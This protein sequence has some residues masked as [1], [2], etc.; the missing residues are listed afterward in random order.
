MNTFAVKLTPPYEK[1]GLSGEGLSPSLT[2]IIHD[3]DPDRKFPALIAVPGGSYEH[4]SKREGEP[5]A[6]RWYSHGYN[7]F[8]LEYSCVDKP[9]PT[10]LLEL[11]AAVEYIRSNADS[12]SCDGRI[13]LCGFSAGGHL[14]ASLGVH[15]ERY[16]EFFAENIRPDKMILCYPVITSGEYTHPL[17]AKNIAPTEKLKALAAL[18]NH[19]SEKTPPTFIWHCADDNIVS[20]ENSLMFASALSK[21]KVPYE[22]HIFPKGGHGIAM[23]DITTIKNNDSRYINPV[24]AEWFSLA[25]RWEQNIDPLQK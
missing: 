3:T 6:A 4:C 18:E 12:L 17:S 13:I 23:C 14:C 15:F 7:G 19:V 21:K 20:A 2:C 9:F 1:A 22:L 5:C 24:A 8:V 25:L 11:A 10:A 16:A